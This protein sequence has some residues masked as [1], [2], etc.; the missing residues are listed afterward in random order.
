MG[1]L[2]ITDDNY[3]AACASLMNAYDDDYHVLQNVIARFVAV[4]RQEKE[5]FQSI[6]AVL[7][8]F[9]NTTQRVEIMSN[10]PSSQH[11][12]YIHL[13]KQRLPTRTLDAWEKHRNSLGS[14]RLP[15]AEQFRRFLGNRAKSRREREESSTWEKS[16]KAKSEAGQSKSEP[17]KAKTETS[18]SRHKPYDKNEK[19][20]GNNSFQNRKGSGAESR[21]ASSCSVLDC[22]QNHNL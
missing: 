22:N 5:S 14:G 21:K 15:S 18:G 7:D 11:Q 16:G 4:G 13:A 9:N 2:A 3:D 17:E 12:I 6:R 20:S 8:E 1:P 19:R 10:D